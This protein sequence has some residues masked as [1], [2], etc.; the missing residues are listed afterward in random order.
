MINTK[1][2]RKVKKVKN[3]RNTLA[4]NKLKRAK[5]IKKSRKLMKKNKYKKSRKNQKG[6]FSFNSLIN[7]PFFWQI[8]NIPSSLLNTLNGTTHAPDP[9]STLDHFQDR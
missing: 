1:K 2:V 6:G 5:K 9:N 3:N 8:E 7:N 4:K